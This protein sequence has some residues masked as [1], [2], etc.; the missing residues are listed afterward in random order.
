MS[1]IGNYVVG[2]E[3]ELDLISSEWQRCFNETR[4]LRAEIADAQ[5][6]LAIAAEEF[7]KI[8]RVWVIYEKANEA[9]L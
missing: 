3:E 6:R 9:V 7:E 4:A 8:D 1:K 5:L 2:Q